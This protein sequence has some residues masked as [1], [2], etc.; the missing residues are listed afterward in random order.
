MASKL[1]ISG[2]HPANSKITVLQSFASGL[3]SIAVA[4]VLVLI[5]SVDAEVY[6]GRSESFGSGFQYLAKFCF[7]ASHLSDSDTTIPLAMQPHVGSMHMKIKLHEDDPNRSNIRIAIFDDQEESWPQVYQHNDMT[8]AS[9]WNKAKKLVTPEWDIDGQF[10]LPPVNIH[11]HTRPR[12]W[13]IVLATESCEPFAAVDYHIEFQNTMTSFWNMEFGLNE[14]GI[15][16]LYLVGVLVYIPAL[17]LQCYAIVFLWKDNIH[18]LITMFALALSSKTFHVVLGLCHYLVFVLN[19]IGMP[20]ILGLGQFAALISQLVFL[21]A[22]IL[23]SNGWTI[24]SEELKNRNF[25]G[26]GLCTFAA[27]H[28]IL[29]VWDQFFRDPASTLYLYDSGPGM[30][31]VVLHLASGVWFWM[32]LQATSEEAN[33]QKKEFLD[34]VKGFSLWFG[35]IPTLVCIA[36]VL[37]PWNREKV[38]VGLEFLSTMLAMLSMQYFL[39][40]SRAGEYFTIPIPDVYKFSEDML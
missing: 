36:I 34:V 30:L 26:A 28:S 24:T 39:W 23:I 14:R 5:A 40:P 15:N 9:K 19:G 27:L 21:L 37:N 16:S 32:S 7:D 18:P 12:F 4:C 3:M 33:T 35:A 17:A 10:V 2:H 25:I 38:V 31:I 20:F 22:L 8:C 29:F 13:Y 11:E 1:L 6:N